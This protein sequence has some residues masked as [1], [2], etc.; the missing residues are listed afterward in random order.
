MGTDVR[1]LV[2]QGYPASNVLGCDL[3]QEFIDA[4]YELY[5]DRGSCKI[6]FFEDD[7]FSVPA[8]ADH[9]STQPPTE[10]SQVTK[11]VQLK[12]RINHFYT[13]A[14]FHLFNE[15][16]Q[17][18]FAL[19]VGALLKREKG[20]IAFGR[21]QGH[22]VEGKMDDHLGRCVHSLRHCARHWLFELA[23][24]RGPHADL[25]VILHRDRYAHS[26]AS[27][28]RMWKRVFTQLESA[29]FAEKHVVVDAIL[30]E[31]FDIKFF[32]SKARYGHLY[33]S[34]KIV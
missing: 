4:G 17:F 18:A 8:T 11:L 19:R 10:L 15:E 24:E 21:D 28:A 20:S 1:K 22:S 34:V 2:W 16:T 14:V 32:D 13:G 3:R 25:E 9:A 30:S 31:G 7:L 26:P 27:W 5:Q 12:D 33:W 6:H 23:M 29:E